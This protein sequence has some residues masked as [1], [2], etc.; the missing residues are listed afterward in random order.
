MM[1]AP[2]W[3]S[4]SGVVD[5]GDMEF[6]APGSLGLYFGAGDVG[7]DYV[8]EFHD[9]YYGQPLTFSQYKD[10]SLSWIE[11]QPS[12]YGWVYPF[13]VELSGVFDPW[14]K[15]ISSATS[16]TIPPLPW[17][18][19][20][21]YYQYPRQDGVELVDP[22]FLGYPYV[23]YG[24]FPDEGPIAGTTTFMYDAQLISAYPKRAAVF[25]V[26]ESWSTTITDSYSYGPRVSFSASKSRQ[27]HVRADEYLAAPW[28]TNV[29]EFPALTPISTS[30][31]HDDAALGQAGSWDSSVLDPEESSTNV[32]RAMDHHTGKLAWKSVFFTTGTWT[33]FEDPGLNPNMIPDYV[34]PQL[35]RFEVQRTSTRFSFHLQNP[36]G[37]SQ[38]GWDDLD[39]VYAAPPTHS[40]TYTPAEFYRAR[41]RPDRW[42][43]SVS[44]GEEGLDAY[45]DTIRDL[46]D[47][48]YSLGF[49][50]FEPSTYV[51]VG[52]AVPALPSA[53]VISRP[54][55]KV[56]YWNRAADGGDLDPLMPVF[57]VE[58]LGLLVGSISSVVT[59]SRISPNGE[60]DPTGGAIWGAKI[61]EDA[62]NVYTRIYRDMRTGG[63]VT[64]F[65]WV[66]AGTWNG[67]TGAPCVGSYIGNASGVVPLGPVLQEWAALGSGGEQPLEHLLIV[68]PDALGSPESLTANVSLL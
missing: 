68:D 52:A 61:G 56:G 20:A 42:T 64:G 50:P 22:N 59:N 12:L 65:F 16:P 66:G 6:A 26:Q 18:S 60:G 43:R 10:G 55:L 48:N 24:A 13:T 45:V 54:M 35:S 39:V 44:Y 67:G 28:P 27:G 17:L 34:S 40:L 41:A 51:G 30:T 38:L 4:S 11:S 37:V 62:K 8:D 25:A 57:R 21:L 1:S 31:D 53:Q 5:I 58:G 7:G 63:F 15:G 47:L 2:F 19:T 32:W 46:F 23:A 29:A 36:D 14:E 9:F 49:Q 3:P 33:Q